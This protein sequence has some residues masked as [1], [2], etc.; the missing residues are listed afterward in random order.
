MTW[1]DTLKDGS[2]KMKIITTFLSQVKSFEEME[3]THENKVNKFNEE[4]NVFFNSFTDEKEI[5]TNQCH[6]FSVILYA[7]GQKQ[8]KTNLNVKI[9]SIKM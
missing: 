2:M 4:N 5:G 1:H 3:R 6:L 7:N 9:Q 8:T